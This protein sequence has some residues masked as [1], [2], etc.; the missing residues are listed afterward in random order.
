MKKTIPIIIIIIFLISLLPITFAEQD[1]NAKRQVKAGV[2][3]I[4]SVSNANTESQDTSSANGNSVGS[5]GGGSG[6]GGGN[7]AN[8]R[9]KTATEKQTNEQNQGVSSQIR[10]TIRAKVN[11]SNFMQ[12]L[13]NEQKQIF[14]NMIRAE[15]KKILEMDKD[16][17]IQTLQGYQLK[18]VD[19]GTMLRKR[20]VTEEKKQ[21]AALNY[22]QAVSTYAQLN[23]V[24]KDK[25]QEF[26]Q[27]K[28]QLRNCTNM[29]NEICS[30]LRDNAL[31]SAK[32][33]LINGANMIIEH[34]NKIKSRIQGTEEIDDANAQGMTESINA[35]IGEIETAIKEAEAAQTKAEVKEA[36]RKIY[37]IWN[38]FKNRER[39]YA[40][41]LIDAQVW[42]ILRS[43]ELLEQ[44]LDN[45]LYSMEEQGINVSD[46]D[47]KVDD[48]SDY[49]LEA[50]EKYNEAQEL[51]EQA[52]NAIDD[53]NA[54][55]II[56]QARELLKEA[57]DSLK[58]AHRTLIDIVKDIKEAG[59]EIS[60][61]TEA[62]E[63]YE[64]VEAE[65][66]E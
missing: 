9:E 14:T 40:A 17:A 34:L 36:A 8:I 57:H 63:L 7:G 59:G 6:S 42:N 24:Y 44:R 30:K 65:V 4:L 52:G 21:E 1:N 39:L 41:K 64:I 16:N 15:Q 18:V 56:E 54:Q 31:E 12:N 50:K 26:N 37:N 29:D 35:A 53:A 66:M 51:L 22:G 25:R 10:N 33:Y 48:F 13:S 11:V 2:P 47:A 49:I 58:N 62:E 55:E 28:E 32:E 20:V 5:S 60:P 3:I 38:R 45:I 27:I 19:K 61:E 43:S 23:S 46:I